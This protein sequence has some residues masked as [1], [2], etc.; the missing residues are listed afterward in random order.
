LMKLRGMAAIADTD[1]ESAGHQ[2]EVLAAIRE[3]RLSLP[4]GCE[5]TYETTAIDILETLLRRP[6][7]EEAL[8][9][10]YRD[11]EERNGIRPTAVEVFHAGLNPR[12]NSEK[13]WLGF[14]ERMGGLNDAEKIG[15]ANA[16]DFFSNLEKT[17]TCRSYKIVLLLAML[18]GEKLIQS[19][20]IEDL[21][22]RVARLAGRMH[23]LAEDFSAKLSDT[24]A[25]RRLLVDNPVEAFIQAKGMG[26]VSYFKFDGE[27]FGFAFEI[28]DPTAF[29]TLIREILDWRLAQ[30]LS[31]GQ[32]TDVVCTVSRS[33]SG[34][35]IL[36]LPSSGNGGGLPKGA[37]D[38]LIDG[39]PMVAV[40]VKIAVNVVHSPESS[41][42]ELPEILRGWFGQE[43]GM[44]GRGDRV[45]FHK[46][47]GTIVME[48]FG[49]NTKLGSGPKVWER[50]S[51][52]KIPPEFGLVFNQ[53]TWNVGFVVSRPHIFLLVTL[54]KDDMEA[55][56]QYADHF[57]SDQEFNWQSQNRTRQNSQHGQMIKNHNAMGMHVHLLVRPTKRTGSAPTP[58][59]YCG[60]VDFVSWEGDTP[61]T[62]HWRLRERVPPSLWP[63]LKVPTRR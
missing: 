49:P 4:T 19:L 63:V 20:S 32:L 25:L 18:D 1:A 15:L 44:P 22:V 60:E 62:V 41:K 11:F 50:Y 34:N 6:K 55:D 56:Y 21:A 2:R 38:I 9:Y 52:E 58:F 46:E 16:A 7:T 47:A 23:R 8:E 39:R 24:N 54:T 28:Q 45:R 14:V 31:R 10:F 37:L 40:V 27:T 61:I 53:A 5:V 57:I 30:Y 3:D 29:A 35:P 42:N 17:E 48:P 26:G 33:S 13:S 51:R 59:I 36:F 12:S 43:A